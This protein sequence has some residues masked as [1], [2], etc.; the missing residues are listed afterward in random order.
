M[1]ELIVPADDRGLLSIRSAGWSG[2]AL[3]GLRPALTMDG[4]D[5]ALRGATV[6]REGAGERIEYRFDNDVLLILAVEA[7]ALLGGAPLIR[8]VLR[9]PARG[10]RVLNKVSFLSS[11]PSGSAAF[12][13]EPRRVRVLLEQGYSARVTPLLGLEVRAA[14]AELEPNTEQ[15]PQSGSSSMYW[16]AYDQAARQALL[17]GYLSS[18]RWLGR[19]DTTVAPDGTVRGWDVCADGGDTLLPAGKDVPLEDFIIAAGPDP[20]RLL[21][22]YA[23]CVRARHRPQVPERP[24]VSWCSWYPYRLSV[25]EDRILANAR[26]AAGRLGPLGL[27][28]MEADLG[29]E[30]GYLPSSFDEN[31][32]FPHGLKWLSERLAELGFEFGVWKA[33]YTVSEYDPVVKAHPEWL[34]QDAGGKP[35]SYWTWF[36]RP[37][38]DV[39]ILDLTHPGAQGHLR[40]KMESLRDRGVRYFKPD[41]ISCANNSLAKRRHD[42]KIVAGGGTEAS[43]LGGKIIKEALDGA[44]VLNC[45]GPE[46]PGTGS[47]PLLYTC[48]DTGNTG[49]ITGSFMQ[50]NYHALAVHL[51]KNRRWGILQPSC[52]CVGLPGGVEEARLRATAAFLSGGQIDI[53]DDFT[54]LPE[55]RWQILTATLPPTGITARPVDLFDPVTEPSVSDYVGS[56]KGEEDGKPKPEPREHPPASVW[57]ARMET[58]WDRWDLVAV[59]AFSGGDSWNKPALSSF[60]IPLSMLGLSGSES[61]EAFEFW[62]GQYLGGVP[63]RRQNPPDTDHPGDVQELLTGNVQGRMDLTFFGPAVKLIS[64]RTRREH[65]WIA[66]TSFH[67]SCGVELEEVRWDAGS[68]TLSGSLRRPRGSV[69]TITISPSGQVVE[70]AVAGGRSLPHHAGARGSVVIQ[71]EATAELTPWAVRFRR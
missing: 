21:E 7:T 10:P 56:C 42:P 22:E 39:Y 54:S 29:W 71:L 5:L 23:D 63:W 25:S 18:E 53:S 38:G 52:L 68:L 37:H 50:S 14:G 58:G 43:R 64:L 19:V 49:Y 41:F 57:H 66:G 36:W 44:P 67:Q 33:P 28:I 13:A 11:A 12:G 55:D 45:G 48:N 61:R 3:S 16:M 34:I 26:I 6:R 30:T 8:P 17:V 35:A 62:S 4:G 31:P 20:W 60:G 59:F 27:T 70:E 51:F 2:L 65:P 9:V 1:L 15:K 47:F 40:A 46:M 24:P 32:Q 69:G